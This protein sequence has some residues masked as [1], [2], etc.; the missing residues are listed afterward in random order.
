MKCLLKNSI[1]SLYE[2]SLS[3][4][5]PNPGS[6]SGKIRPTLDILKVG[7]VSERTSTFG[8]PMQSVAWVK[9]RM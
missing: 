1:R 2:R 4:S 7:I 8:V 5:I 3:E 9:A 6:C